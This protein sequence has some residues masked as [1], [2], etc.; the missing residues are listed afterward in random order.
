[1]ISVIREEITL[2]GPRSEGGKCGKPSSL[3]VV[4]E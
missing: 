1:M 3:L 4:A 2:G